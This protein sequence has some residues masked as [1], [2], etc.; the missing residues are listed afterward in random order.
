MQKIASPRELQAELKAIMAFVHHSEKPDREEVA[1]KLNEL[2][3]RLAGKR[4]A[5]GVLPELEY[6]EKMM[7]AMHSLVPL[8]AGGVKKIEDQIRKELHDLWSTADIVDRV[9]KTD[10]KRKV[11]KLR[12]LPLT[13]LNSLGLAGFMNDLTARLR[14]LK[15][16][17]SASDDDMAAR[18]VDRV[19]GASPYKKLAAKAEDLVDAVQEVAGAARRADKDDP[20]AVAQVDN[21][22]MRSHTYEAMSRLFVKALKAAEVRSSRGAILFS[23]ATAPSSHPG[24]PV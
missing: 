1:N 12:K 13:D 22:G 23:K 15:R 5:A 2:A 18:L 21:M 17:V 9:Y 10:W 19:A 20:G 4:S 7:K 11:D 6:V 3:D 8:A 16:N 14:D 24:G